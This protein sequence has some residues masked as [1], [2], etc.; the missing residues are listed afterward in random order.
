MLFFVPNTGGSPAG[1]R[2]QHTAAHQKNQWAQEGVPLLRW[3]WSSDHPLPFVEEWV[4]T[5]WNI[6]HQKPSKT[7]KIWM[8]YN[9]FYWFMTFIYQTFVGC[10]AVFFW[11]W[12]QRWLPT[13]SLRSGECWK[14]YALMVL[15]GTG[16]PSWTSLKISERLDISHK[17][18][19]ITTSYNQSKLLKEIQ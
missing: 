18:F 9:C 17:H 5:W 6:N 13:G 10:Q 12:S 4:E 3:F 2:D 11:A 15:C 14:I 8:V 7:I 1:T 16:L 19:R